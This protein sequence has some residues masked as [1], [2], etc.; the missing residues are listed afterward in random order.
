MDSFLQQMTSGLALSDR[1]TFTQDFRAAARKKA[2][3]ARQEPGLMLG[4]LLQVAVAWNARSVHFIIESNDLEV[5]IK[6][7]G[8]SPIPIME[9]YLKGAFLL[10]AALE[11]SDTRWTH[12]ETEARYRYYERHLAFWEAL[13]RELFKRTRYH[14][15]LF[16]H[17]R[18]CPIPVFLDGC[19][20]NN[21]F[22]LE[23]SLQ[24]M[25]VVPA[26]T[27]TRHRL[28]A[29]SPRGLGS[30]KTCLDGKCYQGINSF[31]TISPE[32]WR[33]GGQTLWLEGPKKVKVEKRPALGPGHDHVTLVTEYT[34]Q[35]F[36]HQTVAQWDWLEAGD[37]RSPATTPTTSPTHMNV[38]YWL[39]H[40]PQARYP[41]TLHPVRDGLLLESVSLDDFPKGSRLV[42]ATPDLTLDVE[43]RRVIQDEAFR[44]LVQPIQKRLEQILKER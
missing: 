8:A 43:E 31:G 2:E 38:R 30:T 27:P 3:L 7:G 22:P 1:G 29:P 19:R 25:E 5:R 32:P 26:S 40:D 17:C 33:G 34:M 13:K 39:S 14:P 15:W 35:E 28:I 20:L 37:Y 44:N 6:H 18:F 10:A 11:P 21:P 9:D 36:H 41:A 24:V 42:L 16:Q 12:G 23:G 4:R